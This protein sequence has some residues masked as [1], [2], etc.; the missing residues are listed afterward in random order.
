LRRGLVQDVGARPGH[1][2]EDDE[3]QRAAG[4]VDAVAHRVGAEQAGILLG[5]E[6][7]DQR[8]GVE[9]VDMLA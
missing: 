2:V 9:R 5:A 6:D 1:A 4:H 3:A 8:A 7:V